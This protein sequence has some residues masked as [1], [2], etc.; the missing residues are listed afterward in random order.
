MNAVIAKDLLTFDA[1][2]NGPD[3]PM[4]EAR[5]GAVRQ[6]LG[7]RRS[8]ELQFGNGDMSG[9]GDRLR[10]EPQFRAAQSQYLS[11]AELSFMNRLP[12][13]VRAVG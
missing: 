10:L 2:Y 9:F 4:I 1:P 3:F 7:R 11:G 5:Q 6:S 13:N 8:F 12:V